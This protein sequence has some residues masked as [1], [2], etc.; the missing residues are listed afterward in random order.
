MRVYGEGGVILFA[1]NIANSS[2]TAVNKAAQHLT[3][4]LAALTHTNT[5]TNKIVCLMKKIFEET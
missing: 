5:H 4:K 3:L 1:R 2:V